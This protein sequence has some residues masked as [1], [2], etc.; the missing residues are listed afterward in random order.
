MMEPRAGSGARGSIME[1]VLESNPILEAFGNA[2]TIRND[3][4]SRFGKFIEL[5]FDRRGALRGAA[6]ETYLLEK[7]RLPTHAARERNF[8]IFYQLCRAAA[9][10]AEAGEAGAAAPDDDG[11]ALSPACVAGWALAAAGAPA[12]LSLIHI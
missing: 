2:R 12:Y 10:A 5:H 1:R 11:D 8:H 7:V 9:A 4:S 3:N 6:I